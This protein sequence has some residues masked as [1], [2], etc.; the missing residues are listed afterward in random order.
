[1]FLKSPFGEVTIKYVCMYIHYEDY[2]KRFKKIRSSRFRDIQKSAKSPN[3]EWSCTYTGGE[4]TGWFSRLQERKHTKISLYQNMI[5]S[6][7][8]TL[9][10]NNLSHTAV[11]NFLGLNIFSF[12]SNSHIQRFFTSHVDCLLNTKL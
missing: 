10:K 1:M 5:S 4:K 9:F 7:I 2:V 6:S 3:L 11:E 12:Y 8:L